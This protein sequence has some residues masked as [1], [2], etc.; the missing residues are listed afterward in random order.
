MK[1]NLKIRILRST[2]TL[3]VNPRTLDLCA[4]ISCNALWTLIR[5]N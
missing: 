5:G 1:M 3:Q 2:I 4:V